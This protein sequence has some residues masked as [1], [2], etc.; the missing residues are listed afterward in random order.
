MILAYLAGVLTIAAPCILPLLPI[1]IAPMVAG[2]PGQ[3]FRHRA[4]PLLLG[5]V[6]AFAATASLA[7]AGGWAV[8]AN[9]YGRGVGLTLLALFGLATIWPALANRLTAPLVA[10][11]GHFA[12]RLQGGAEG[13]SERTVAASLLLGL[14][15]GL[16]WAPCAGPVLGLI[17]TGAALRG[18]GLDTTLLLF[19]YALGAATPL[20]VVMA[21]GTRLAATLPRGARWVD[22]AR[23]V[24]GGAVLATALASAV[25]LDT[26]LFLGA[27][28]LSTESVER[29]L[30]RALGALPSGVAHAA[31]PP[32]TQPSLTGPLAGVLRAGS[33]INT[34][35][36]T[37]D[38]VRGRVVLVN[39]WTYS[40]INCLRTLPHIRNWAAQYRDQGLVVVG[41]HTPEFAFERDPANVAK[42]VTALGVGYPVAV[43]SDFRVWRAFDNQ[44]WPAVY[45]IGADGR[46]RYQSLG[47]GDFDQTE[48]AIRSAL[49]DAK[50]VGVPPSQ[51]AAGPVPPLTAEGTQT[52]PDVAHLA[53]PET[54]VGY[55][56]GQRYAGPDSL[57]PD[58]A[59]RYRPVASLGLNR[60]TLAG[61]WMVGAEYATASR[62]QARL[63][64]RF[65]ARDLHL[66][67]APGADG[68][69]VR[70]RVRIDGAAPGADHGTDTDADGAGT[71]H[72]ARLYQ[73]VRQ[74]GPVADRTFEIEFL[75][76]GARVYAFT[77]G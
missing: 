58:A 3:S 22:A 8:A 51:A 43:D 39:F 27:P 61:D 71:V 42:A 68:Q 69:P 40:C 32:A 18:P 74:G 53:S 60:W 44:G 65:H 7:A 10:A 47:E 4:L 50:A 56:Q 24:L 37:P 38:D 6:A 77:F 52:A 28:L 62:A 75:D 57:V 14:A 46:V 54:Y 70:F 23:Q 19:V 31:T 30:I 34:T 9:R 48:R 25:G 76:P 16:V 35:G 26:R 63:V 11:G 36:L 73:L 33:W 66:V 20:A 55:A 45:L 21:G 5:L 67:L 15:T 12:T 13:G 49:A 59:A 64:Y 41:V 72:A 2:R 29:A 17:L 1:V